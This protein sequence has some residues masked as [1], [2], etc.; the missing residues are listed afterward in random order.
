MYVNN[1][2]IIKLYNSRNI[3]NNNNTMQQFNNYDNPCA[4]DNDENDSIYP[5]LGKV[6]K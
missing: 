1:I 3:N 4:N 6:V 2:S 5:Y